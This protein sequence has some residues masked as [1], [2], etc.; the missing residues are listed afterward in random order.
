MRPL[1]YVFAAAL[2]AAVSLTGCS[3]TENVV[4][5]PTPG[6]VS[7][8]VE[9]VTRGRISTEF[10]YPGNV[11][12]LA[13]VPI[14]PEVSGRI[15]RLAVDVGSEVKAGDV[16]AEIDAAGYEIQVAQAEA[17]LAAAEAQVAAMEAGS[18]PEQ[19]AQARAN[20][21]AARQRLESMQAGGR[22]EQIAQ[23]EA[24][25]AAAQARLD[26]ARRGPT[27]EQ[28]AVAEAQVRLARNNEYYQQ[29][30]AGA[31]GSVLDLIADEPIDEKALRHAQLGVAWEQTRIAEA[32]LAQLLAGATDEEIR[33]LEAAVMAAE[34]QLAMA[35]NPYTAQDL[36]QAEAAVVAA[37]QQL[38]L[39]ERPFTENELNA[40]RAAA[41]Q[42]R[43][44]LDLAK[45]QLQKTKITAPVDGVIA[46][47]LLSEGAMASSSPVSAQ[48]IAV[49]VS[50]EVEV[51]VSVEEARLGMLRV[52]IPVTVTVAAYPGETFAAEITAIAPSVDPTSRTV[53]VRIRPEPT[54]KLIDGMF[55]QVR[56]VAGES[57]E[58]LLVPSSAVMERDG[59]KFVFVH[60][61]GKALEREVQTGLDNG[62]RIEILQGLAEGDEVIV[63][64]MTALRDG[65]AVQVKQG[66]G[67]RG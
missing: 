40:A 31:I 63:D 11:Q 52:G 13:R 6:G 3:N 22:E 50:R 25:L 21:A 53:T 41:D 15:T 4:S 51:T 32:Q 27:P 14:V 33:Q 36:A 57:N 10:V 7:V 1:G 56:I 55:A 58:A 43:A 59:K 48:P 64:G 19:L 60:V 62:S 28:I 17:A 54:P 9:P 35:K 61:D 8:S 46:Q 66:S 20:L 47:R 45:L 29:Q 5:T 30:R 37:E 26:Q 49:L 23:A 12:A 38:A 24:N 39:A 67:A 65:Q 44:A 2:M 42:A 34:Q 18:R 16:I